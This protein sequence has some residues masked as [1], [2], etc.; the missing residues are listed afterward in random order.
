MVNVQFL[1][2][3]PTRQPDRVFVDKGKKQKYNFFYQIISGMEIC[4]QREESE[5]NT[6][7]EISIGNSDKPIIT[8]DC[9]GRYPQWKEVNYKEVVLQKEVAF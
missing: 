9:R 7:V 6:R 2:I 8:K 5:L 1:R 3:D 4:T